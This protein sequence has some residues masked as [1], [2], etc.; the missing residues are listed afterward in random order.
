MSSVYDPAEDSKKTFC[1]ATVIPFSIS[2]STLHIV[3]A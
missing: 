2:A 1:L 3:N